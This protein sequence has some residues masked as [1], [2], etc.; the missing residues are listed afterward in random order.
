MRKYKTSGLK[1]FQAKLKRFELSN[2]EDDNKV[3][4]RSCQN[5]TNSITR[6]I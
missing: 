6:E 3:V 1:H 4:E 5:N 2:R